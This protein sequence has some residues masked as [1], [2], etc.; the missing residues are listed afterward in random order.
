MSPH[1]T[2]SHISAD[3]PED[4]IVTTVTYFQEGDMVTIASVVGY[5]P[6]TWNL[7]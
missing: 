4:G 6:S 5:L 2:Y 7:I 3:Y 1:H